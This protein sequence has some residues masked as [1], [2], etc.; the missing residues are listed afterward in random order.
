[1]AEA[2]SEGGDD[3]L[4]TSAWAVSVPT[5]GSDGLDIELDLKV[6]GRELVGLLGSMPVDT[7]AVEGLNGSAVALLDRL[8]VGRV[9][10]AGFFQTIDRIHISLL[11]QVCLHTM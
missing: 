6:L 5:I 4:N 11:C 10:I 7:P 3:G 2:L 8:Q 9:N 1:M